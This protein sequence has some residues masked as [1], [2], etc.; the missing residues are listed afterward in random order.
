[1]AHPPKKQGTGYREQENNGKREVRSQEPEVRRESR[2][3]DR[4]QVTRHGEPATYHGGP[5]AG[6]S[7]GKMNGK[8]KKNARVG[9]S[10]RACVQKRLLVNQIAA[11]RRDLQGLKPDM[12]F[13]LIRHG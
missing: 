12:F 9:D 1:M 3:K 10:Q 8:S 2:A 6:Q 13:V 11:G 5:A 7:K 4:G